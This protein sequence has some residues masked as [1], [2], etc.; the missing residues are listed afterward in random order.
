VPYR[1]GFT[2]SDT[3]ISSA[4]CIVRRK[5]HEPAVLHIVVQLF[6]QLPFTPYTIKHLQQQRTQQL[7]MRDRRAPGREIQYAKIVV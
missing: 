5:P 2:F 1:K 3:S 7:F 4:H 6:N